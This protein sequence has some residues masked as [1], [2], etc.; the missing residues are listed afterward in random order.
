[1]FT[2]HVA[3]SRWSSQCF[4]IDIIIIDLNRES[5]RV[6]NLPV[7]VASSE[8][9]N[10]RINIG[11]SSLNDM[12]DMVSSI[13]SRSWTCSTIQDVLSFSIGKNFM[14]RTS[15]SFSSNYIADKYWELIFK[16]QRYGDFN[17]RLIFVPWKLTPITYLLCNWKRMIHSSGAWSFYQLR[18][19]EHFGWSI[20]SNWESSEDSS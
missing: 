2:F 15:V 20:K 11:S 19:S 12:A 3:L 17:D 13:R 7:I 1:M 10:T 14:R 9:K 8:M 4:P 5:A 18:N 16:E 6:T